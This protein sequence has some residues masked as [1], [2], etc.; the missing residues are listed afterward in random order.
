MPGGRRLAEDEWDGESLREQTGP[1]KPR[2]SSFRVRP[3]DGLRESPKGQ[4]SAVPGAG[5]RAR[6]QELTRQPR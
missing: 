6:E 5:G 1:T 3:L 2:G 4:G